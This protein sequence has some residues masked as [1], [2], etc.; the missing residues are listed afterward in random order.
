MRHVRRAVL[1]ATGV[2]VLFMLGCGDEPTTAPGGANNQG[3]AV[4]FI[5]SDTLSGNENVAR[6]KAFRGASL[7]SSVIP[8]LPNDSAYEKCK[9]A[10]NC[11]EHGKTWTGQFY[12][13]CLSGPGQCDEGPYTW[14]LQSPPPGT[15]VSF[16]PPRSLTA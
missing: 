14:E 6:L 16:D 1:A 2:V 15:T 7:V 8:P 10:E 11:K 13:H 5:R 3:V 12:M 4:M 9:E